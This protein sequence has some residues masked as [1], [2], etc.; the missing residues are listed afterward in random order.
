[1]IGIKMFT[2]EVSSENNLIMTKNKIFKLFQ[3]KKSF[4]QNL[5]FNNL[6]IF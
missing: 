5:I 4:Q 1:M 2:F 3:Q 6:P